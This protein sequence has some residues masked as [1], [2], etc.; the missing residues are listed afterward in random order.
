MSNNRRINLFLLKER[1]AGQADDPGGDETNDEA[2]AEQEAALNELETS[3]AQA[4][5]E[6]DRV[7]LTSAS[8]F[9]PSDSPC[10]GVLC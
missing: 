2:F 6:A 7:R 1:H 3:L 10:T 5:S 8:E 9:I 4:V